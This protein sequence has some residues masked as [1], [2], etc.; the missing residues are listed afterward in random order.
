MNNKVHEY[1]QKKICYP[2]YNKLTARNVLGGLGGIVFD[3]K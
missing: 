2:T 3:P 1:L